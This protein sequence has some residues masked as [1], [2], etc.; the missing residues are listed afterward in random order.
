[1]DEFEVVL[2]GHELTDALEE[3]AVRHPEDMAMFVA[4]YGE[5]I[6]VYLVAS[7]VT[8]TLTA[9]RGAPPGHPEIVAS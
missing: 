2:A 4:G 7:H 1:M 9:E 5:P 8:I 3:F 6:L